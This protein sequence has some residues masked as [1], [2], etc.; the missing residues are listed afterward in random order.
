MDI[1]N[2]L[3]LSKELK[4]KEAMDRHAGM[5]FALQL[6]S[7]VK[8]PRTAVLTQQNKVKKC[9]HAVREAETALFL[10]DLE[11]TVSPNEIKEE[12]VKE[13]NEQLEG[14]LAMSKEELSAASL[15]LSILVKTFRQ[16]QLYLTS[17][18][19]ANLTLPS[20]PTRR[21]EIWLD[22]AR[23]TLTD[24][25]GQLQLADIC[26]TNFSYNRLTF[27]DDSGEHRLELG[28]FKVQNLL[29][30]ISQIYQ[31]VLSPYDPKEKH[32]RV[33]KNVTLRVYCKDRAPVAGILVTEHLEVNVVP[34]T[35]SL[36]SRF[37]HTMQYFFFPKAEEITDMAELDRSHLFAPA[38]IQPSPHYGDSPDG[39]IPLLTRGAA[40]RRS[41]LSL[42]NTASSANFANSSTF[43]TN[44]PSPPQSPAFS[45]KKRIDDVEKMK[46]RAT[47]TKA[48]IYV[49]IPQT[50]LCITYKNEHNVSFKDLQNQRV[51]VPTLEYH[52]KNWT[53]TDMLMEVKKDYR[54][55]I[56]QQTLKSAIG[57]RG[58]DEV[59]GLV[60][61]KAKRHGNPGDVLFYNPEVSQGKSGKGKKLLGRLGSRGSGE[62]E[63][64]KSLPSSSSTP[65]LPPLTEPDINLKRTVRHITK[66]SQDVQKQ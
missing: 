65:Y 1:I 56:V 49:K 17:T 6:S 39:N 42:T 24:S 44:N 14:R 7:K 16:S 55:A 28:T 51:N 18:T 58:S 2:N 53:W 19:A 37:F 23:W 48:F 57:M 4:R 40:S 38:G 45:K 52:N 30:N 46:D 60:S 31:Q 3:L 15:K 25:D 13:V 36:T 32:L 33:D 27:S 66:L 10:A 64:T 43:S 47:K 12:E 11:S 63:E 41:T 61:P 22:D 9:L 5:Q 8:D 59:A 50:S 34:L 29:P 21:I 54:S 35:V 20:D 26:L 62:E